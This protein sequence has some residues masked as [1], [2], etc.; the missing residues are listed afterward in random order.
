MDCVKAVH[1][2]ITQN[3]YGGPSSPFDLRVSAEHSSRLKLEGNNKLHRLESFLPSEDEELRSKSLSN[4]VLLVKL[5]CWTILSR[6]F[7]SA[8]GTE[9]TDCRE[10]AYS[11]GVE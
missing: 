11:A 5:S 9:A 4:E 6:R 7:P 2:Y 3:T 1:K 10:G 8:N